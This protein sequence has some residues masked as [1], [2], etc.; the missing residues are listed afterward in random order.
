MELSNSSLR[1]EC[2]KAKIKVPKIT[3][4]LMLRYTTHTNKPKITIP[5][6]QFN[7]NLKTKINANS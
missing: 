4:S 5:K 1:N 7:L 6:Q 2:S 3:V